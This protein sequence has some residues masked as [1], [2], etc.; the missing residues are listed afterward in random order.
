MTVEDMKNG[1]IVITEGHI[2]IKKSANQ[3]FILLFD[4]DIPTSIE[5]LAKEPC[6]LVA[7][8]V[9]EVGVSLL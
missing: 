7:E 3:Y 6:I 5:F 4:S 9:V 8:L 1:Q 2:C